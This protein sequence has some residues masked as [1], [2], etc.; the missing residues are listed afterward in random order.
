MRCHAE[1]VSASHM[2][3][4]LHIGDFANGMLKQVQHDYWYMYG[5]RSIP[6]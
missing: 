3:V 1:L 4:I 6:V 2:L 5:V